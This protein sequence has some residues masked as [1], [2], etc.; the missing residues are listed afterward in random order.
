M[1]PS[2]FGWVERG[3]RKG[4]KTFFRLDANAGSTA[5][6]IRD[7]WMP[8]SFAGWLRGRFLEKR[9]V[10]NQ[11]KIMLDNLGKLAGS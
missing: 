7:V 11:L 1:P 6:T 4:W 8:Q 2:T 9:R 10:Q 3:Q 5:V